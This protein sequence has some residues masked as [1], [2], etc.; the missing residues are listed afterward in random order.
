MSY[1]KLMVVAAGGGAPNKSSAP[2]LTEAVEMSGVQKPRVLV[3][4]SAKTSAEAHDKTIM[5]AR[6]LYDD[7]LGLQTAV[8]HEFGAEPTKSQVE[9]EIG[10]ADVVY[11]SGGDTDR[12]M[13]IWRR[14]GV[15]QVM[16]AAA[17]GGE[18]VLSGISAGAIAPFAWGHSDSM[19]YRED[20]WDYIAVDGLGLVP[21]AVTPHHNTQNDR[22]GRRADAF[23][24]MFES[25][26]PSSGS[27]L[28]FGIDNFAALKIHQ[29]LISPIYVRPEDRVTILE[30]TDS[31]VTGRILE[32]SEFIPITSSNN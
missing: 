32:A 16:G 25:K 28:G 23:K 3:I 22:L 29:G 14:S 11:I 8:L 9:H 15:A 20:D 2:A 4:P 13:N 27:V 17:L 7:R 24:K 12:M 5:M 31:I 21:A 10:A 6:D 26:A 1:E 18:L 19:S 30:A